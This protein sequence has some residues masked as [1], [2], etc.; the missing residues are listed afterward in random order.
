MPLVGRRPRNKSV[1]LALFSLN[2]WLARDPRPR[3]NG[4]AQGGK[5]CRLA[6]NFLAVATANSVR[7]A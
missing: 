2:D 3:L 5:K 4:L 7:L 6:V 1:S